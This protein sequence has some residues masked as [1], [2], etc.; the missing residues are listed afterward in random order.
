[1][2]R[3]PLGDFE[4]SIFSDGTYP[5][6]G[7]AFFGVVPKVMWSRKVAT[8]FGPEFAVDEKNCVITGLN[9]LL[10]RMDNPRTGRRSVLVETGMGNKLS[11]RMIKFYGQ[12]A[13]LLSNLAAAGVAPDDIDIVINTHLHFDHCG[14]NTVRNGNGKIAPT[15]PRAKYCAP[16]GEWQ[17]AR[18]PSERDSISYISENYDPLVASG[19]MTL[20]K[21]GEEIVPGISVQTFPGHTAN[22]Q[23]VIVQSGGQTV[24]YISDLIPTTAHIDLTWGMSFDLYPLQTI[25]SKKHY[26]AK[27]IPEKWLTVF[28]HDPKTPWAYVEK[29]ELGKMVAR[30]VQGK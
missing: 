26:Y 25:A 6:D 2:H 8:A 4:L 18:K 24:C 23:A 11:E 20:L 12:P 16:E 13:Q 1:M 22:M 21:G 14:W 29:D 9:S 3:L 28:T 27:S 10:I 19:Q 30:K 5:L 17:Y 15:F 7:G